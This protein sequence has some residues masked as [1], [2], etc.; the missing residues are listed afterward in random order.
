MI[1]KYAP[2]KMSCAV[3]VGQDGLER[4]VLKM[5]MSYLD[6]GREGVNARSKSI[7]GCMMQYPL[8]CQE[9]GMLASYLHMG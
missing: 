9:M 4:P 2:S 1:V 5:A 3:T 8:W 7:R 6:R